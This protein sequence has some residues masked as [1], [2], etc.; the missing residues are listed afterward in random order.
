MSQQASLPLAAIRFDGD[1]QSRVCLDEE[2][3]AEYAYRMK[4]GAAFPPITVFFDGAEYW[5]ADGF[6]RYAASKALARERG[7]ETTAEIVAEI[8]QGM[9]LDA[10]RHALS[11]NAH[12]GKR[13]EP[14]DFRKG[15]AIAVRCGLCQPHDVEAVRRLLAC[16][17][18]WARE[19]TAPARAE[20][21]QQ[22][23]RQAH[24]IKLTG[25]SNREVA[26]RT[27][28]PVRTVD[29]L[30]AA[31]QRHSADLAQQPKPLPPA[32]AA[33]DRPA[34]GAW[35]DAIYAL[36]QAIKALETARTHPCPVRALPRVLE[37]IERTRRL[38]TTI[39]VEPEDDAA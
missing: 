4:E 39:T 14:G 38:L 10:V 36:E 33:L 2:T 16:S 12:H 32:V 9:R 37:L 3:I 23:H 28:I 8:R 31:P 24:E 20:A 21:E 13:R 30:L 18:R 22:K 27:G 7:D 5:L 25:A 15:Y 29:R 34:L 35:S 17:E 11:A 26:R 1:C 6:H 19:L